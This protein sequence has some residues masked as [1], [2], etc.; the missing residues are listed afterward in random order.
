MLSILYVLLYS[1]LAG[2]WEILANVLPASL[3]G[4]SRYFAPQDDTLLLP[5]GSPVRTGLH[6][7]YVGV[8]TNAATD[9]G[10]RI[11]CMYNNDINIPANRYGG[12]HHE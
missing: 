8:E 5:A 9:V 2:T 6:S 11:G 12:K 7:R 10:R 1:F 3:A 4:T